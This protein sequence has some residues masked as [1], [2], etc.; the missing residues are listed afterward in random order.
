[1]LAGL[2]V[3]LTVLDELS[4]L[5]GLSVPDGLS[6]LHGSWVDRLRL[7]QDYSKKCLWSGLQIPRIAPRWQEIFE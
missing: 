7:V 4:V 5:D 2:G 1:M 6:V 3:Q